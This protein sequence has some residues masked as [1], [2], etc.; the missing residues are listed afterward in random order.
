MANYRQPIRT[1]QRKTVR[2]PLINISLVPSVILTQKQRVQDDYFENN[3]N[4][5][6]SLIHDPFETTFDRIAKGAIVPPLPLDINKNDSWNNN[7]SDSDINNVTNL[8]KSLKDISCNLPIHNDVSNLTNKTTKHTRKCRKPQK[9]I[10]EVVSEPERVHKKTKKILKKK[11]RI[12]SKTK[13][14]ARKLQTNNIQKQKVTQY[15]LKSSRRYN[16]HIHHFDTTND[17]KDAVHEDISYDYNNKCLAQEVLKINKDTTIISQ[18]TS[19]CAND[20]IE[21]SKHIVNYYQNIKPCF[22]KLDSNTVQN[23]HILNREKIVDSTSEVNETNTS[24]LAVGHNLPKTTFH[25]NTDINSVIPDAERKK[26]YLI[27]DS[28]IKIERLNTE[29]FVKKKIT[30]LNKKEKY[31]VSSTPTDKHIRSSTYP[32]LSPIE[33]IRDTL[34]TRHRNS[35][36][37]EKENV[38]IDISLERKDSIRSLIS[39]GCYKTDITSMQEQQTEILLPQKLSIATD[40]AVKDK[41]IS[42]NEDVH[43]AL[44]QEYV[45]S[46]LRTELP[47]SLNISAG[48]DR[49][50]SLFGDTIYNCDHSMENIVGHNIEKKCIMDASENKFTKILNITAALHSSTDL[51]LKQKKESVTNNVNTGI[52]MEYMSPKI[53]TP[54]KT[55]ISENLNN[56]G[57]T[58]QEYKGQEKQCTEMNPLEIVCKNSKNETVNDSKHSFFSNSRNELSNAVNVHVLLTKLQDPVRITKRM[59]YSKWH[60]S[61]SSMSESLNNKSSTLSNNEMLHYVATND[62][63]NVPTIEDNLE[64]S[65]NAINS[66]L[67]NSKLFDDAIK[68]RHNNNT[69]MQVQRSVFLKPGKCWARSLSI[70][71]NV[72]PRCDLDKLCAGKGK[73]WRHSVKH[74]LDMQKQGSFGSYL[75][76]DQDDRN[77]SCGGLNTSIISSLSDKCKTANYGRFSKRISVRV[78]LNDNASIKCDIKNAPFLEA[79]GITVENSPT[80]LKELYEKKLSIHNIGYNSKDELF[81]D[82]SA[83]AKDIVLQRCSQKHYLPFSDCFPDSYLEHCRKIGEGVY[84]EVFL[85]EHD[86]EKSVIKIIPIEGEAVVNGEPQKKFS[87]ILSEIVIAE[88]LH[89][90]RS[91]STYRTSAF[92]EVR[93]IK[94]IIGK[95]PKKLVKLWNIYD[96]DKTSDNDC[97]SMF[98]ENQLYI[99]LELGH[100]G[101]DLE[102]FIFQT[103]EEA[104]TLFLQTALALA[105]AEKAFEF[106]HRDLHWGNVLISRTK[107]SYVYYNLNGKEIKFPSNNVKVSIIDYTL[108]RIA[109]QG[110]CIYNDLALDPALFTARGEYQFEIYRLMRDKIQNNWQKFEPY[111]NVLWLHYTLDKMITAVRYKKKTLKVHKQAIKKLKVLKETILNYESVYNFVNDS[112][113]ITQYISI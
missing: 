89:N 97:P 87:E 36:I 94:C 5:N 37:T 50:R 66:S 30:L 90:L 44:R 88:E 100:G 31:M 4:C 106:E 49:S 75:K 63:S 69:N 15:R 54:I 112:N 10:M 82:H 34:N 26:A 77:L 38:S 79:F 57:C 83:T 91:H 29:K 41:I 18:V 102:A 47:P 22:I 111:T 96:D 78:V 9:Y 101:K 52:S 33:N 71:S 3:E 58:R 80:K 32:L 11:D 16:E 20:S 24:H 105:V 76:K 42:S 51:N 99:A 85:Y 81:G 12:Q 64:H 46:D 53:H 110:C 19:N 6:D 2:K 25:C 14:Q 103:A 8:V 40:F 98:G 92:V 27:K 35:I 62:C 39:S 108:S 95:Y 21:T 70:L 7:S 65:K 28:F 113:N 109:Y 60:P 107:E 104:Y 17:L 55:E 13:I 86:D 61:V 67:D 48:T 1:Y 93:S 72:N 59:R 56:I 23:W 73:K 45:Q 43:L 84:G 68:Q 74:I